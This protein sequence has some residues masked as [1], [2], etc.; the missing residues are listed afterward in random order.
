MDKFANTEKWLSQ[1]VALM[2]QVAS[3]ERHLGRNSLMCRRAVVWFAGIKS[4]RFD[5]LKCETTYLVMEIVMETLGACTHHHAR[6]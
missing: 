5:V 6:H 3:V 2:A 1:P 4:C